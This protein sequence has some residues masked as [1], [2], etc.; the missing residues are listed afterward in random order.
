MSLTRRGF[1]LASAGTLVSGLSR[2]ARAEAEPI[3]IGYLAAL[4]GPASA[5]T[6]GFQR[7]IL[8]AVEDVNAAGGVLGR[9]IELITRDTQSD[10]T[11]A[12]NATQELIAQQKVHM[13]LGPFN[14]GE[15]LAATPILARAKMPDLHPCFVDSLI[16]PVKYPYAYR[17]APYS[18]QLD[19]AVRSYVLNVSK[20]RDVAVMGDT[21]GYGTSAVASSVAGFKAGGA[22]VVYQSLIDANQPDV[23]PD[24]LRA[25]AAGAKVV[26]LWSVATGM[27]AR[28]MNVRAQI[29]WDV[30]FVGHPALG[31]GEVR[32]L[33]DKPSNWDKVYTLGFRSC[34]YNAAGKLPPRTEAFVAR[35]REKGVKLSDTLLWWILEGHDLITLSAAAM[36]AAGGTDAAGIVKYLNAQEAGWPGLYCTY[37]FSPTQHNGLPTE[38]IVMSAANSAKDGAYN[39]A[40]GYSG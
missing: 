18:G 23:K 25:Q 22:N 27:L 6:Q 5:P 10:P 16:D 21:T 34:S 33:L 28:L 9:K 4:T 12:V 26:V 40:P 32:D 13:M 39:M 36:K 17:L 38:E 31:A 24:L 11:K 29:G 15:S 1:A 14:S 35:L 30:P 20:I 8:L 7:G 3:K 2:P 19:D 37:K